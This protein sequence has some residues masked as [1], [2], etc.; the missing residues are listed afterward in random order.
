MKLT[1][2]DNRTVEIGKQCS[3]WCNVVRDLCQ[4]C[5]KI[6]SYCLTH[7]RPGPHDKCTC[8]VE[9]KSCDGKI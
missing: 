6:W 8:Q 4:Q 2:P 7:R 9:D 1:L 3:V 5:G